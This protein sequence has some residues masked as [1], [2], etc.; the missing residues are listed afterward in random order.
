MSLLRRGRIKIVL[1]S[2]LAAMGCEVCNADGLRDRLMREQADSFLRAMPDSLQYRQ[3]MAV[4]RAISGDL[5]DLVAVR[6]SRDRHP[7]VS[8]NVRT[9]ELSPVLRLYEPVSDDGGALPLLIYLHG[10]GWAFGSINSCG[11]F[12]DAMAAT[13][14]MKVM[15]VEYR[16][17]PENPYPCGY[18]DC[19]D[20]IGYAVDNCEELGI[21]NDRISVGGDSAG[22]NLAIAASLSPECAGK[23]ESL[24][25]FYPV[26]LAFADDSDSWREFGEGYGLDAF[27][28]EQFNLAYAPEVP[29]GIPQIDVG[30]FPVDELERLPRTLMVAAG[31]DILRDQGIRFAEKVPSG[32]IRRVEFSD[33][34]HLFITVPGQ[35]KAFRSAVGLATEFILEDVRL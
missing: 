5:T 21:D 27:L 6:S 20:A 18:L 24:V 30:T 31:R 22:G 23:V 12:C 28:M 4:S 17:A 14:K 26:V 8:E 32:R 16:L 35:E 3:A 15:A 33:A 2:V 11:R 10:G 1:I 29:S 9:R 34:V 25:L 7:A 19:V 13:G